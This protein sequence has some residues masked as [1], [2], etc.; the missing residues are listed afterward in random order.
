MAE[1]LKFPTCCCT[2]CSY[3]PCYFCI[4][5]TCQEIPVGQLLVVDSNNIGMHLAVD[6]WDETCDYDE[7]P[8]NSCLGRIIFG[9]ICCLC[10]VY[11]HCTVGFA[12]NVYLRSCCATFFC[13][14]FGVWLMSLLFDIVLLV[15]LGPCWLCLVLVAMFGASGSQ[16]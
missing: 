14:W 6:N 12:S 11:T 9:W 3:C 10:C 5:V 2:D 1:E 8:G 7:G 15:L 4:G 16:R 13:F